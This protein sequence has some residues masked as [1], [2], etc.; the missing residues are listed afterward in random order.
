M[1]KMMY[2]KSAESF[3]TF[4]EQLLNGPLLT[5]YIHTFRVTYYCDFSDGFIVKTNNQQI[6]ENFKRN[7]RAVEIDYASAA[8]QFYTRNKSICHLGA[9]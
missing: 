9:A 1:I 3:E 2:F 6:I 4:K 7:V 5:T 8:R